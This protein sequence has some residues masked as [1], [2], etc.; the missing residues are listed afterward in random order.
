MRQCYVPRESPAGTLAVLGCV[1]RLLARVSVWS[2]G[3]DISEDAVRT[4]FEALTG[5][6]YTGRDCGE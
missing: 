2:M 1:D 4:S 5:M 6:E 3:C